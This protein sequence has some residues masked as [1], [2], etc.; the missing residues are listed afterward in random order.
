MAIK[1]LDHRHQVVRRVR[2]QILD[3]HR[4]LV[5]VAHH[6]LDRRSVRERIPARQAIVQH[7]AEAVLIA[8]G[9]QVRRVHDAFGAGA[10]QAAV[11]RVGRGHGVHQRFALGLGQQ[12][13]DAE[14]E[15]LH[16]AVGA[17]HQVRRLEQAVK[18]ALLMAQVESF[19]S[20][21]GV[22]RRL[23]RR[24]FPFRLDHLV[25]RRA[26]D[27]R[28]GQ[29]VHAARRADVHEGHHRGCWH[30][31]K[32]RTLRRAMRTFHMLRRGRTLTAYHLLSF[33]DWAL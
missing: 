6:L 11:D 5:L 30:C 24:Q 31:S 1:R 28:P 22:L 7:A 27:E 15:D 14:I 21:E 4:L 20:L 18:Q 10:V 25:Q 32:D 9:V 12:T 2:R 3:R 26:L 23:L 29:V 33:F 16:L 8:D 17:D 19:G 13:A